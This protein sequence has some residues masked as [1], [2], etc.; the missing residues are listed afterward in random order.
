MVDPS[1]ERMATAGNW[2]PVE[3]LLVDDNP[4]D[5]R[6]T[7]EA[8]REAKIANKL[9]V[10]M[11]GMEAMKML[12]HHPP[13]EQCPRPDLILLDLNLPGM[14]GREILS[15]IKEDPE[16]KIIPVVVL[17]SSSAESDV[18][19]SYD[20]H[21][22]CYIVKPVNFDRL[23]EVVQMV[24]GFWLSLVRLPKRRK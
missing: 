7:R 14:D 10:A 18:Q 1:G 16:L 6:L 19:K 5:V 20:L 3:I 4:G 2:K 24:E 8:L 21:A 22:N 15:H 17:T 11:D 23:M 13:H 12:H 9:T